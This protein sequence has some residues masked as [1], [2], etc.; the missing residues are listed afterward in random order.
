M[1]H[2]PQSPAD[3]LAGLSPITR[4]ALPLLGNSAL[5]SLTRDTDFV[6]DV[7]ELFQREALIGRFLD[8]IVETRGKV[9]DLPHLVAGEPSLLALHVHE[10]KCT[11]GERSVSSQ[12]DPKVVRADERNR[13]V[14]IPQ[15]CRTPLIQRHTRPTGRFGLRCADVA[16]HRG[17]LGK[18]SYDGVKVRFHPVIL[19][20]VSPLQPAPGT[21][22]TDATTPKDHLAASRGVLSSQ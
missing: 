13:A 1:A 11:G 8:Q 16:L 10:R 22:V 18:P 12:V 14:A 19:Q 3:P 21:L 6:C 17:N 20:T 2:E 5:N 15:M 9:D 4:A 7:N